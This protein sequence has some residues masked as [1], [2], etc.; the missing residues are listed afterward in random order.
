MLARISKTELKRPTLKFT[1]DV[2]NTVNCF[3]LT[4]P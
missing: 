3:G 4:Y 2:N 1:I